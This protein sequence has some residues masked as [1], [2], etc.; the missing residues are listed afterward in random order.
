MSLLFLLKIQLPALN[1]LIILITSLGYIIVTLKPHQM[2]E[3]ETT[4]ENGKFGSEIYPRIDYNG[5]R[6]IFPH[7][8]LLF[9][10]LTHKDSL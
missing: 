7:L 3:H 2:F 9:C 5:L 8:V 4:H 1:N 6:Y 10:S